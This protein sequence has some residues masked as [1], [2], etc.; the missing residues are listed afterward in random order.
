MYS[1][2]QKSHYQPGPS[3]FD[4]AKYHRVVAFCIR[5]TLACSDGWLLSRK[6]TLLHTSQV[7]GI[8]ALYKRTGHQLGL[9][10]VAHFFGL[11]DLVLALVIFS[12]SP[13]LVLVPYSVK[14]LRTQVCQ[15]CSSQRNLQIWACDVRPILVFP[16]VSLST[17]AVCAEV[18][19]DQ[20][21]SVL[22]IPTTVRYQLVQGHQLR[23]VCCHPP[24]ILS[25]S[26]MP[27][28]PPSMM[29]TADLR[30]K[31]GFLCYVKCRS[32]LHWNDESVSGS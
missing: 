9:S 8:N 32:M 30:C 5:R 27:W 3:W 18:F 15:L 11:K 31:K 25:V 17:T 19:E 14:I 22:L 23:L 12:V 4:W 2:L 26:W 10:G 20:Y 13:L 24:P 28:V 1:N 7:D 16:C 21:H 29:Q 6:V